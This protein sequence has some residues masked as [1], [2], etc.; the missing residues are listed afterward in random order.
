MTNY[1]LVTKSLCVLVLFWFWASSAF[2]IDVT[3]DPGEYKGTW[4]FSGQPPAKR[5]IATIDIPA[6]SSGTIAVSHHGVITDPNQDGIRVF[7]RGNIFINVAI[8]GDVTVADASRP[9]AV[10]GPQTLTFNTIPIEIDPLAYLGLYTIGSNGSFV[11]GQQAVH[12]VPGF[13]N[14]LVNIAEIG[15]Q[16][17]EITPSGDVLPVIWDNLQNFRN[18]GNSADSFTFSGNTLTFKNVDIHIDPGAYNC[19]GC[20]YLLTAGSPFFEGVGIITVVLAVFYSLQVGSALRKLIEVDFDGTVL[21]AS[22]PSRG[23]ASD[24]FTFV[25]NTIIFKTVTIDINPSDYVGFFGLLNASPINLLGSNGL[26][27]FTVVQDWQYLVSLGFDAG[28]VQ[29]AVDINGNTSPGLNAIDPS[30]SFQF[31]G[32][33]ITFNT[34]PITY[35]PEDPS[36]LYLTSNSGQDFFSGTQ[37]LP[38]V[39]DTR[40]YILITGVQRAFFDVDFPCAIIPSETIVTGTEPNTETFQ[41]TCPNP[42]IDTDL[43]GVPDS[44]DN[45]PLTPN[46]DQLDQDGDGIG[47]VCD[48]DIDGDGHLNEP[49]NCPVFANPDQ[50]DTD[51]DGFGDVCDG[52]DDNDSVNDKADNCPL[53][54]NTDQADNDADGIGDVCDPDDDNDSVPDDEPDNC[55]LIANPDQADADGD[56]IGDVCDDDVDGDGV[57]NDLDA[58]PGTSSGAA[59]TANGCSGAQFIELTCDPA[60]FPNHGQ[61]VSCVAHT[62]KDLVDLGLISAKEKARFVNQAAKNK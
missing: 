34:V 1:K 9:S 5:G 16:F 23:D 14:V 36:L 37:T 52:D 32:N 20:I 41:V 2:A 61:F 29:I 13:K 31:A 42:I 47:D 57:Q 39:F 30:N 50:L 28:L 43:D 45:C 11:K 4:D 24:S 53:T 17:I 21:P 15:Q 22:H 26:Q 59:I 46:S 62:A 12:I 55:R 56:G 58:C 25:G 18:E 38:A 3:I 54:P 33:L 7:T 27:T 19:T 44:S 40:H 48:P 35:S 8:N 60:N 49:D 6:G 51:N 10:G